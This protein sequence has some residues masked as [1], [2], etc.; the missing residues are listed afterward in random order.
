MI[1]ILKNIFADNNLFD[2]KNIKIDSEV[3]LDGFLAI[4][5]NKAR[6][7]YYIIIEVIDLIPLILEQDN[8]V[9]KLNDWL[10]SSE[11]YHTDFNKNTTLIILHKG[12]IIIEEKIKRQIFEIEENPYIFKKYIIRYSLNQFT[13]ITQALPVVSVDS[14]NQLIK[15]LDFESFKNDPASDDYI[16][17]L[18]NLFIKIP[19]LKVPFQ[20]KELDDLTNIINGKVNKSTTFDDLEQIHQICLNSSTT[21]VYKL[22]SIPTNKDSD[23]V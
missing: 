14:I 10:K 5:N 9:F 12:S 1:E 19:F 6:K 20:E 23:E 13:S 18:I 7:E 8:L 17:L 11:N 4:S 16:P 3:I 15:Q 22:F 21:D 2:I